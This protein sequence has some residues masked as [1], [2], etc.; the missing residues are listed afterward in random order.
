[1]INESSN[2]FGC[3]ARLKRSI[4]RFYSISSRYFKIS[5]WIYLPFILIETIMQIAYGIL[6]I[7]AF[8]QLPFICYS[9]QI[10]GY[11]TCIL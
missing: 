8:S 10:C 11:I 9:A 5:H 4:F 7:N 3:K 1:M 2:Q 6:Y